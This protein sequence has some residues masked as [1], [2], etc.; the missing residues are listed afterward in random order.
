MQKF[1]KDLNA[2]YLNNTPLWENDSNW[3]GFKWISFDDNSQSVIS[4]RRINGSGE[5][6]IVVCNFCPVKRTRYRIGVPQNG[7]YKCVFSTDKTS[8]GGQG[9]RP[10]RPQTKNIPMHGFGQSIALTL[11]AMS[12][13]YY[14]LV[15]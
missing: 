1:V 15:K 8:Y 10:S 2:F 12:V 14:K 6:I 3:D 7:T 13:V 4:F 9:T 5:E 11:P